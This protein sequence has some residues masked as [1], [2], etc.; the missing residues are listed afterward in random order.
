M[1]IVIAEKLS[2]RGIDLLKAERKWKVVELD[3]ARE[4]LPGELRD[5]N[6]LIIRSGVQVNR[7]LLERAPRLQV[8][9][10]AGIGVDNVD[11]EA[12][13]RKGVMV[14]TPPAA[15]PSAWPSTPWP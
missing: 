7:Q 6:A 15:T 12:A 13:T 4:K 11:I 1:K 10:R 14:M 5:A 9:G 8:I 3:S 2:R